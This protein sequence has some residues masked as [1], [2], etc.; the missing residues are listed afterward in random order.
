[1]VTFKCK[2]KVRWMRIHNEIALLMTDLSLEKKN[3]TNESVSQCISIVEE[4]KY[5][6]EVYSSVCKV[7][8]NKYDLST[9]KGFV[10]YVCGGKNVEVPCSGKKVN[11]GRTF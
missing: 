6:D 2:R 8:K 9:P 4:L 3:A 10:F 7:L 5:C 11:L 1:M